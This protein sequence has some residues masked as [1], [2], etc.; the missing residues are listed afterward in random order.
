MTEPVSRALAMRAALAVAF[1]AGP[2]R[3]Q[4]ASATPAAAATES[5]PAPPTVPAAAPDELPNAGYV[6]GYRP[7]RAVGLSPFAPRVGGLPGGMTPGYAAP[8]PP[9]EWSFRWSGF[10][11]ASLQASVNGRAEPGSGQSTTVIHVPPQTLDE[12]GSF[13]GTATMPGQWAQLN[14]V[15]GNR[16][17]SANLSLTTWNP[18]DPTTFYSLGSQQF[19]NN[20]FLAYTPPPILGLRVRA[21]A[22]YFHSVYGAIGQYGL[23]LYTNPLIAAVHGVG[24]DIVV[25]FDE[26][27]L[28]TLR[29]EDGIIGNRNGMGAINVIPSGQ[30]GAGSPIIWPSAWV[31]HVHASLER[32]GDLTFRLGLHYLTNWTQDDR[33]QVATD[34][35]QTRQIDESYVRDGRVQTY[36]LDGALVSPILGFL[37]AAISYTHA[38][39][40]YPVKGL[41]TFGGDGESLT[42]RWFGQQTGGTGNL[43]ALGVNYTASIGRIVSYPVAFNTDG[44]DLTLN[45]GAVLADSWS[46]FAPFDG[47]ARYKAGADLYYTFLPFM[48]AGL[49][50]DVVVPSSHDRM[51]TFAVISPRLV[52]KSDWNSRDTVS[53]IYGKWLYGPH[54]HAETSSVT[55]GDRLDD[56]LFAINAQMWW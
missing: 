36:G 11:S 37:G 7:D 22:G 47:R 44:P 19:I 35:Q 25:E 45:V 10:L 33:L 54:S 1:V 5:P 40:A 41:T 55:P 20:F 14:F 12:Y 8:A 39:D 27:D 21:M 28:I 6:P 24:E 49:R 26:G 2:A 9:S 30:N 3:A 38:V 52:F 50:G 18:S 4:Q 53:V 43:V 31:H 13:V 17:V 23:G 16:Y 32:R 46:D 15:Y 56:Q 48:G 34:N 51:E 42:N 29:L